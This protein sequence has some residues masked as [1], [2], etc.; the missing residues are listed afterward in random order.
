MAQPRKSR[1]D[2]SAT[3]QQL[4]HHVSCP[5]SRGREIRFC[6][7]MKV[8]RFWK[9]IRDQKSCSVFFFFFFFF[10]S[11]VLLGPHSQ[12]MEVPRLGVELELQL[13]AYTTATA[14]PDQSRVCDLH[15]S[16]WQ[17]Q[18]LDPLS[19]TRDGTHIQMDPSPTR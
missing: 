12:R 3:F 4:K 16:S 14:T 18:I 7:L 1:G 11:F 5:D 6:L 10:W 15:Q 8:A 9:S 17:H 2:T 19:E 13:P